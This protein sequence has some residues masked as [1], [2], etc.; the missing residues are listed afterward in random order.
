MTLLANI[1]DTKLS[2]DEVLHRLAVS[3]PEGIMNAVL[4]DKLSRTGG[5]ITKEEADAWDVRWQVLFGS[6]VLELTAR[7][8]TIN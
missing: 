1:G 7:V 6:E 4:F 3:C 5:R 8:R 2:S